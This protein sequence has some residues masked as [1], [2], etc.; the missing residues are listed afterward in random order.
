MSTTVC[1]GDRIGRCD[2]YTSGNGTYVRGPHIYSS[3]VGRIQKIEVPENLPVLTVKG[4]KAVVGQILEV[5]VVVMGRVTRVKNNLASVDILCAGKF[6]LREICQGIIRK[7]DVRSTEV[8]KVDMWKCFRP[9]DIV[10]TKVISLGNSRD[11]FLSTSGEDLGVSWARSEAGEVLVPIS[12]EQMQC[13]KTKAV[14][15]RKCAKPDNQQEN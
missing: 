11:Y 1:P 15:F 13:P 8:D 7:E 2:E 14:E 6:V 3:L 12:W 10:R 5:G 4:K 9:G